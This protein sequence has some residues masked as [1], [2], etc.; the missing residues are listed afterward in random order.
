MKSGDIEKNYFSGINLG[1]SK[2]AIWDPAFPLFS[3]TIPTRK[4]YNAC[5]RVFIPTVI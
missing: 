2:A 1:L 5:I 4:F 3:G